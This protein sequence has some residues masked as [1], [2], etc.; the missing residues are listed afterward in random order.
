VTDSRAGIKTMAMGMGKKFSSLLYGFEMI[1]PYVWVAVLSIIGI[2]P[3]HTVVIF[4][5]LVLAISNAKIMEK[6]VEGGVE[7]IADLDIKTANLQL[8]FSL[9]LTLSFVLARVL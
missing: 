5:T 7:M 3:V 6:S 1:F 9:L 4:L 8:F 2:F